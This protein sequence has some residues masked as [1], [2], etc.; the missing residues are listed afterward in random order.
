MTERELLLTGI[1]G[2]GVQ[3][4]AQVIARAAAI[5]RRNVMLFGVYSGMMRGGSS[6][7]T[8]VVADGPI[9]APPL[10]SH[11]WSAIVM[12][13]EFWK[14]M[15]PK[16]RPGG[17]IL[18]NSSLFEGTFDRDAYRVFE[19]PVT[20]MATEL[21]NVLGASMVIAGAYASLTGLVSLGALVE[22]MRESVP[23]YR[24]QH[25][26]RNGLAIGAG[27]DAVEQLAAPAWEG[28]RV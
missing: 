12:H 9:Q 5:D 15:L 28:A 25:V 11:A 19:L 18:L 27:F 8:V 6:D 4:P 1:G 16:I 3:L 24:Q 14:P 2:Q 21:G 26:A 13:H 17:V 23:P 7:S 22:G 10:V 20:D